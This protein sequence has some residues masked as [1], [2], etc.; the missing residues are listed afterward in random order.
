MMVKK[1]NISI[2]P[3]NGGRKT[4]ER[5]QSYFCASYAP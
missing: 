3:F 4:Q 1:Q 5:E 2:A